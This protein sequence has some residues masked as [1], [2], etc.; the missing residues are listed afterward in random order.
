M[1][2]ICR[3]ISLAALSIAAAAGTLRA[4]EAP[5]LVAVEVAPG[6]DVGPAE[7]RQIVATELGTP[8]IG[9]RE[10]SADGASDVLLVALSAHL[11][12]TGESGSFVSPTVG[13]RLRLL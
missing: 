7:V 4:A 6:I 11:S 3:L 2:T 9:S 10:S 5:L 13:V 12:S 1:T 8:V